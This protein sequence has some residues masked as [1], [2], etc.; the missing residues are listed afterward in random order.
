MHRSDDDT[1]PVLTTGQRVG[2]WL[3]FSG[4]WLGFAL[5]TLPD[6][7]QFA[8]PIAGGAALSFAFALAFELA[9]RRGLAGAAR[10][11]ALVAAMGVLLV[12]YSLI[13]EPAL[14]RHVEIVQRLHALGA[15]THVPVWVG[16]A[17]ATAGALVMACAAPRPG[18]GEKRAEIR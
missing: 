10:V 17:V 8:G 2:I 7:L 4:W 13:C 18:Q 11:G 15:V 12:Y 1:R 5:V 16:G 14:E 6:T 9:V 3:G